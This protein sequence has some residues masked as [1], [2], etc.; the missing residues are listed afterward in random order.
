MT[1]QIEQVQDK[2]NIDGTAKKYVL[3]LKHLIFQSRITLILFVLTSENL[4]GTFILYCELH[5][6]VCVSLHSTFTYKYL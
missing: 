4:N 1:A 2:K 3:L 6:Y 5:T